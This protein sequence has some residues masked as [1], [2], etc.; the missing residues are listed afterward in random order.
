MFLH[1]DSQG[2]PLVHLNRKKVL[3]PKSARKHELNGFYGLNVPGATPEKIPRVST[4]KGG[5]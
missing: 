5:E 4:V 2:S 3:S 1:A